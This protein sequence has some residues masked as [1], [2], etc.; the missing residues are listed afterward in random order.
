MMLKSSRMLVTAALIFISAPAVAEVMDKEPTVTQIWLS[1]AIGG[2]IG[3]IACRFRAWLLVIALPLT[4][5]LPLSTVLETYDR[6]VGPDI[7]REA[8]M[9]YAIQAH[10]ALAIVVIS[11][12]IGAT[13]RTLRYRSE[14]SAEIQS[15]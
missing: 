2:A 7:R 3:F 13:L 1:A 9:Q 12:L 6:F 4:T 10:L 11:N 5:A 15:S 8:G 14:R